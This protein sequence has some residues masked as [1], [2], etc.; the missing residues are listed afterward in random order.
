MFVIFKIRMVGCVRLRV[1]N[2]MLDYKKGSQFEQNVTRFLFK[3]PYGFILSPEC[4]L[5]VLSLLAWRLLT[6]LLI[7][8]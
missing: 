5:C 1:R 6:A 8:A 3:V 2:T 4:S 7:L